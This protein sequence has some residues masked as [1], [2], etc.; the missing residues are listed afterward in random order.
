LSLLADAVEHE[1]LVRRDVEAERAGL[2]TTLI[3]IVASV[4]G[5]SVLFASS[6]TFADPYGTALGQTVLAVVA[7]IYGAGL[8]WM[9]RLAVLSTGARFMHTTQ[10][11]PTS[12]GAEL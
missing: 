12:A 6:R 2:R 11:M 7:A 1:V 10:P 9:R 5:L 8:W 3:V 4:V